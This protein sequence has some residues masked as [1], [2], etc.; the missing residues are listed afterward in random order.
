MKAKSTKKIVAIL[1]AASMTMS[2]SLMVFA[3]DGSGGSGNEGGTSTPPTTS[4][5]SSSSSESNT[6]T[7]YAND[8]KSADAV[9][10]IAGTR[11]K[12][13]MSGTYAAKSVQGAAII[14][15][16]SDVVAKLGLSNKQKPYI[17]MFD[18]DPVKSNKAM[19]CINASASALGGTVVAALNIELGAKQNGKFVTLSDGSVNMV[20][21]LPKLADTTK[22]Y[23]IVRVQPGGI[24]SVFEDVDTNPQ[25]VTFEVAAGLGAYALVA[26]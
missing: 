1:L 23:C 24:I 17:M 15:S 6:P 26:R 9:I 19:D 8:I 20:V 2:S 21:G 12:T 5:S 18:T 13:S 11:V 25:T 16:L 14:T 10:S 7:I 4:Q 3:S 22:T